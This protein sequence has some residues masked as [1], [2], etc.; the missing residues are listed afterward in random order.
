MGDIAVG[1]M[2][3]VPEDKRAFIVRAF[4]AKQLKAEQ[5]A[6]TGQ[7]TDV[8]VY[9]CKVVL[10]ARFKQR[11]AMRDAKSEE[12]EADLLPIA[13]W[14]WKEKMQERAM[15]VEAFSQQMS[16]WMREVESNQQP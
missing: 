9:L 5:V 3:G 2:D 8:L 16:A 7:L 14:L 13:E 4:I 1:F 11:V 12:F 10:K 6:G 15:L